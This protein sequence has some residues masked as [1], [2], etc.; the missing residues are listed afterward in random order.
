MRRDIENVG[1]LWEEIEGLPYPELVRFHHDLMAGNTDIV[2][3]DEPEHKQY[4]AH[5][6][7]EILTGFE[8]N[9]ENNLQ[10]KITI[11]GETAEQFIS[12]MC[13]ENME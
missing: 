7:E 1:I 6:V 8:S 13:E 10:D 5:N 12:M 9:E 3:K 4:S 11:G 2:Y